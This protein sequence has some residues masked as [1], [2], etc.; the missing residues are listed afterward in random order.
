MT[1]HEE[2]ITTAMLSANLD[3]RNPGARKTAEALV[4]A[5]IERRSGEAVA[6][7]IPGSVAVTKDKD[8]TDR[9]RFARPYDDIQPLFAAPSAGGE[10]VKVKPLEWSPV[11]PRLEATSFFGVYSVCDIGNYV[12]LRLHPGLLVPHVGD[13]YHSQTVEG[14]KA[15]AQ[16][17]YEQRILSALVP[18]DEQPTSVESQIGEVKP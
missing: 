3:P 6:W 1:T 13:A 18:H 2:A 5:Y 8:I 17:D 4:A 7:H 9:W 16:R 14:A 12:H 10:T 11:G 15:A